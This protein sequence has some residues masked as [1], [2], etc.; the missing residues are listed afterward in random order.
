VSEHEDK[1]P[2]IPLDL[3]TVAHEPIFTVV[4][5][6]LLE[7]SG[8]FFDK[9]S[10]ATAALFAASSVDTLLN[11]KPQCQLEKIILAT[12]ISTTKCASRWI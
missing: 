7:I 10:T 9:F 12:S 11:I 4:K 8:V 3:L 6:C 5:V 1:M 2:S